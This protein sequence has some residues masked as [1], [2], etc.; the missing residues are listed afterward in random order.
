MAQ[1]FWIGVAV[2]E[3][4][5]IGAEEGFCAFAHG[6]HKAVGKLSLGDRFLYYATKEHFENGQ[7]TGQAVQAFLASG[8]VTGD[9]RAD[10]REG[11]PAFVRN[12]KYDPLF[13][14]PVKPLINRLSF[15]KNPQYWGMA[16]RRSLFE[17]SESDY[18]IIMDAK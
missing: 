10:E 7:S 17:I 2:A 16:F 12:A 3:H 13:N 18:R 9:V 4:I 6:N 8:E 11:Y 15:I 1:R 14:V 5:R